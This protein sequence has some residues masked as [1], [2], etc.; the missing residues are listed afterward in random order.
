MFLRSGYLLVSTFVLLSS[1]KK[2][3]DAD[4]LPYYPLAANLRDWSAP[5]PKDA[6]LRFR[7]ATTGYVR[8]YRVVTAES[9]SRDVHSGVN[10]CPEYTQDY[11]SH[12][13]ERTDSTNGRENQMLRFEVFAATNVT[14]FSSSM[15]V[16][17]TP[18]SLPLEEIEAGTLALPAATFAGRT[19]P[20]VFGYR[21][22]LAS[23]AP[24]VA[25]IMYLT[26][27]NGLIRFEERG[28][29]VWDR[30]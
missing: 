7:N 5:Y 12:M 26:K 6:V 28:G 14:R 17:S 4:D 2:A 21:S 13:L 18:F 22:S 3:C 25:L 9:K 15:T 8:S 10:L 30:L 16:G 1:C 29:T 23:S 20:A 27:A 11:T 19:Y 24:N